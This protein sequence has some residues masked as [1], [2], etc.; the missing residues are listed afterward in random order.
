MQLTA[1]IKNNAS[2][3]MQCLTT[4]ESDRLQSEAD[5][6]AVLEHQD[7]KLFY[8]PLFCLT[9]H[10]PLGFEVVVLWQ[11]P[12]QG[13]FCPSEFLARAGQDRILEELKL[14]TIDR[15]CHQFY[16]WQNQFPEANSLVFNLNLFTSEMPRSEW[17]EQVE[18]ILTRSQVDRAKLRLELL[19]GTSKVT[20]PI[21]TPPFRIQYYL[22]DP[23]YD[24]SIPSNLCPFP[25][26]TLKINARFINSQ[27][28]TLVRGLL[29]LAE[30]LELEAIA[31]G[32]E[33]DA[34]LARVKA[35]AGNSLRGYVRSQPLTAEVA[36]NL[37][38]AHYY[39][40]DLA[41]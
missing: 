33:T 15:A 12:I 7:L 34:D 21:A 3:F 28:W 10:K 26:G 27:Q 35:L 17:I 32:L 11:Q 2:Q 16:Q 30:T 29:A 23:S 1:L 22:N 38:A 25:V 36:T 31:E 14:W 9:T 41:C 5:W 40:Q 20:S 18:Q 37:I 6:S 4:S 19:N 8:Q 13:S 24:D 39:P